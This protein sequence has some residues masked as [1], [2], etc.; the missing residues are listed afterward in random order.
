[1]YYRVVKLMLT[2]VSEVRTAFIIRAM[3]AVRTSEMSGKIYL[4]TRHYIPEDYKHTR[5]R[6]N[7]ISHIVNVYE[8]ATLRC[9]QRCHRHD[10]GGSMYL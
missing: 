8:E 10:D 9:I 6:E 1:M 4:T 3:E 7:L 2:D 5:R